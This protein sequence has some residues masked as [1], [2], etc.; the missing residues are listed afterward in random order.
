MNA[1]RMRMI[2]AMVV[3]CTGII[4]PLGAAER[5]DSLNAVAWLLG[6]WEAHD[7]DKAFTEI[8]IR[9]SDTTF[10][11]KGETTR[12]GQVVDGE[13]LRLA[14]MGEGVFYIAKVADNPM[15]IAFELTQCSA[16]RLVFENAAH[17]FPNKLE[18]ELRAS[19][20]MTARATGSKEKSFTL[21]YRRR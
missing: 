17:D 21:T 19:G 4:A 8:W 9:R 3:C 13:S 10:E 7:K 6:E 12:A 15:P 20:E 2:V 1:V 5:C 16:Q 14:Q 18:Y 11:G